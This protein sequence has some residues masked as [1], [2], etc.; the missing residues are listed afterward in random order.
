MMTP[1]DAVIGYIFFLF[2]KILLNRYGLWET[3]RPLLQQL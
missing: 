2:T 3:R 1:L